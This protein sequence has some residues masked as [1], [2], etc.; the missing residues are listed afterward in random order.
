MDDI[1]AVGGPVFRLE[2]E[3]LLGQECGLKGADFLEAFLGEGDEAEELLVGKSRFL[4]AALNFDEFS[5]AGH[6][7]VEIYL[8]V[9]VLNVRKIEELAAFV[10]ANAHGG[11]G[12]GERVFWNTL[13][14]EECLDGEAGGKVGAGDRCGAGAAVGLQHVAVDP[15]SVFSEFL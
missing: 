12:V 11:D 1:E 3:E 2:L 14:V 13:G 4:A 9:L 15:E 10:E 6:D 5:L 8:G 7:D